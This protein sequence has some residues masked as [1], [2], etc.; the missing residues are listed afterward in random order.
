MIFFFFGEYIKDWRHAP[1][2]NPKPQIII[3][4]SLQTPLKIGNCHLL[5]F[6]NLQN[7]KRK[8][9]GGERERFGDAIRDRF[10]FY[11]VRSYEGWNTG[12][13]TIK[14]PDPECLPPSSSPNVTTIQKPLRPFSEVRLAW[15][16]REHAV[17]G[18]R[19]YSLGGMNPDSEP[20]ADVTTPNSI[21][22]LK[23]AALT[24]AL[25]MMVGKLLLP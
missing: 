22:F 14:V 20:H 12:W 23:C 16:Y 25:L 8:T 5:Y 4:L 2:P 7:T 3:D 10:I 18:S 21:V 1:N 6:L 17:I 13:Y 15:P 24:L 11:I 19:L 9:H